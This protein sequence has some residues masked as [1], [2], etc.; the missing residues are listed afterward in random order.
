LIDGPVSG[1]LTGAQAGEL[2][3]MASG[4]P[5]ALALAEP[6]MRACARTVHKVG[7]QAGAGSQVKLI[8]QLLTATHIALTAEAVAF[9]AR[10]GLDPRVLTEVISQSAGRSFQFEKRAPRMVAGDHAKHSTVNIFLK[11]LEIALEGARQLRFP[12]PLTATAHQVFTMA[13]GM[14]LAMESDTRV[15]DVYERNGGVDVAQA[16]RGRGD[17]H[18]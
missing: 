8:N 13:A 11:D 2:T 5:D 12:T 6:V 15:L 17:K 18:D 16:G 14:G 7:A 1:G 9:G 3:I 4:H 10:A